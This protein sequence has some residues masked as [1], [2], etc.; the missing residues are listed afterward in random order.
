MAQ[1]ASKEASALNQSEEKIA[2]QFHT[3]I[4]AYRDE[5]LILPLIWND[6]L[7][8]A[9]KNHNQWM[10]VN[11]R[12]DHV[13]RT[14]GEFYTGR[15]VTDRI[16]HA[17]KMKGELYCGENILFFD[18]IMDTTGVISD[19]VASFLAL[20]AFEGWRE[21]PGHNTNM[22]H[23]YKLHGVAFH[24]SNGLIWSTNVFCGEDNSQYYSSVKRKIQLHWRKL[25][26][27]K[28]ERL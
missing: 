14:K 15:E 8:L 16:N 23:R 2:L 24:Y 7:A 3:L 13:E 22:L 25:F 19:T 21:S 1:A 6:T 26:N 20:E 28:K 27:R 9:A 18:F 12:L 10:G 11:D 4:N 17:A 5:K